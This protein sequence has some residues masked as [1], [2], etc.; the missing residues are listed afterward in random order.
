MRRGYADYEPLTACGRVGEICYR[1]RRGPF[2][3]AQLNVVGWSALLGLCVSS[4]L[5][6]RYAVTR[7]GGPGW[8]AWAAAGVPVA[9]VKVVDLRRDRAMRERSYLPPVFIRDSTDADLPQLGVI[10][11]SGDAAFRGLGMDVVADAP[12]PDAS[13]FD[14]A[15]DAGWLFVAVDGTDQQIG[16]VRV[17]LA[18]GCP[19]VGQ[20]SVLPEHAGRHTGALLLSHAAHHA[21]GRG[22]SRMT[23]RTFTDVPWNAPYYARL[24]WRVLPESDWGPGLRAVAA[25]ER[26][27]GLGPWPRQTMV[28]DLVK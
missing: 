4:W 21:V 6:G 5:I 14:A 10:E 16:F 1:L 18:D 3:T 25:S 26:A 27:A 13:V 7:L 2:R 17:E 9:V 22:F 20:V 8:L 28:L 12:A 23:L 11:T 19:H 15:H 24:G